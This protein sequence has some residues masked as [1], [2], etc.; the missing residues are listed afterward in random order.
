VTPRTLTSPPT[1]RSMWRRLL[2]LVHPDRG[3]DHDVFIWTRELYEHVAGDGIEGARTYAERRNP[4]PRYPTDAG[5]RIPFSEAARMGGFARLTEYALIVAE[6]VAEPYAG[7]L[8]LLADCREAPRS[9]IAMTRQ[10]RQGATYKTLAAIAHAA[11]MTKAERAG[12]YRVCEGVPLSQR[13]ASH[14]MAKLKRQA[15]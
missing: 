8:R 11:G 10:Q 7:L 1:D 2:S 14:I 6:E 3:G 4:P 9:D 13:H 15:A 5:D 12:W